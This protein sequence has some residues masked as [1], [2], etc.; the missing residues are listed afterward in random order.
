MTPAKCQPCSGGLSNESGARD[1]YT[2]QSQ[3]SH[4]GFICRAA[5]LHINPKYPHLGASPDGVV[6]CACCGIGLLEIKCPYKYRDYVPVSVTDS[7]F[8]LQPDE[9]GG[10]HLSPTH[11]YFIQVQGQLAICDRDY[12]DFV[13][14]TSQGMHIE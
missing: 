2:Q 1:T 10:V 6:S 9:K 7:K 12:C 14:W 3:E 4:E 13:C 11:E 8:C 5:G